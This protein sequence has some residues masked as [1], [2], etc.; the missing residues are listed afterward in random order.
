MSKKQNNKIQIRGKCTSHCLR[1]EDKSNHDPSIPP[2]DDQ[3]QEL[4][5]TEN[6]LN[7]ITNFDQSANTQACGGEPE[8]QKETQLKNRSSVQQRNSL[9]LRGKNQETDKESECVRYS[10]N[11]IGIYSNGEG[12]VSRGFATRVSQ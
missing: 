6:F 5:T 1:K 10:S 2:K 11:R 7:R 9:N 4:R 12:A 3:N 8:S